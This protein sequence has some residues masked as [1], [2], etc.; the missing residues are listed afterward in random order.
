MNIEIMCWVIAWI[1]SSEILFIFRYSLANNLGYDESWIKC[2]IWS[3][4]VMF[5]IYFV[6]FFILA[7]WMNPEAPFPLD[8]GRLIYEVLIIV[9]IVLLFGLNKLIVNYIDKK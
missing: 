1:I 7:D 6:Q 9:G 2:K 3:F 8:Y 4:F 5:S